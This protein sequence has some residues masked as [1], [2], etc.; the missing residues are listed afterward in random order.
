MG[1]MRAIHIYLVHSAN[2]GIYSEWHPII[3]YIKVLLGIPMMQYMVDF[4]QKHITER[5]D[6]T[7]FETRVTRQDDDFLA[8]LLTLHSGDPVKFTIYHVLMSCF[9]NIGAVSDTTSISMAAVMYHLMKNAEAIVG[10][11]SWVAHRN[12]D[13][14][15]ADADTYRP[16]RWLESAKRASK[17]EK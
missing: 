7:K 1:L 17:M 14:F 6:A 3:S 5:L 15:G 4:C 12:K 8:K 2:V 13:V 11:N 9:T 16:E 10:V